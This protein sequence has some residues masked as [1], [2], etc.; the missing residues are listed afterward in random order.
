[1]STTAP[2]VSIGLPVRN[3]QDYLAEAIDSI[4]AQTWADFELVISDNASTDATERICR[5]YAVQ[6]RRI[7]YHRMDR[8]IGAAGNFNFVF[9]QGR[10]AY[11]KWAAADDL[12]EPEFLA[13]CATVLDEDPQVILAYPRALILDE[14][15]HLV[16]AG[17]FRY[18]LADLGAASP[19]R[20][21][22]E[23]FLHASVY[24]IF[25][26]LR[27]SAL[28]K[29][30]LLRP[31]AG[32]DYCLL[33]D[34]LLGGRFGEVPEYLLRLRAHRHGYSSTV[35]RKLKAGL[36]EGAAEAAWWDPARP[37][38]RVLPHWRRISTHFESVLRCRCPL[39]DK[40]GMLAL[41]CRVA[42]WWR[43]P[44]AREALRAWA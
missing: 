16:R 10:G 42:N 15:N 40:A 19:T 41:L 11:F 12:I 37:N 5:T 35:T 38:A 25:G 39:T 20:R 32:A 24:P 34:L 36:H 8:D 43:G 30:P 3:G 31:H 21:L 44:L 9:R 4:L 6:D 14:F 23:M 22:R 17:T 7:R 26:L 2:K 18:E 28:A 13:R 1:M 27:S 29:T 33:V